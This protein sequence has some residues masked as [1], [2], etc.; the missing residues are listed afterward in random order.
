MEIDLMETNEKILSNDP[1]LEKGSSEF[2]RILLK[3]FQKLHP[4]CMESAR[5]LN[6]KLQSIEKIDKNEL[7]RSSSDLEKMEISEIKTEPSEPIEDQPLEQLKEN[8]N[9][10]T[11]SE[12][13]TD[14]KAE[15]KI[16]ETFGP[17]KIEGFEDWNLPMIRDFIGNFVYTKK[18]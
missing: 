9:I 15:V 16:E 11:K 1:E 8:V 18:K 12:L 6:S 10:E 7:R 13:K 5:S 3:E 4:N 14:I 2:N 17:S